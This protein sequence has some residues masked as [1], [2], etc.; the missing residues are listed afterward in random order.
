MSKLSEAKILGGVGAILMLIGIFVPTGV[1]S[2]IGLILIFI[3]VKYIADETKDE[4]IFKNYLMHFILSIIA[5]VAVIVVMLISFGAIGGLAFFNSL[6]GAEFTDFA[7][8][9]NYYVY[10]RIEKC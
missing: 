10:R 1:V 3:A 4:E 8:F 6:T 9:L 7:S 5:I 2:I